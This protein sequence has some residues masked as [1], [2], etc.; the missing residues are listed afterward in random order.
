MKMEVVEIKEFISSLLDEYTQK[1]T[2]PHPTWELLDPEKEPGEVVFKLG[3]A[4]ASYYPEEEKMYLNQHTLLRAWRRNPEEAKRFMR[5]LVAEE[6]WHHVQH[7]R[8]VI[9]FDRFYQ[10]R[11]IIERQ[12]RISAEQLSGVSRD[13][14]WRLTWELVLRR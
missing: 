1:I 5:F 9:F 8:G 14:M 12:A 4:F 11:P 6:Y 10:V 3:V 2:I 13:E 7:I